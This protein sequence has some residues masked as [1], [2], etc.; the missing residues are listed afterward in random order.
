M[1]WLVEAKSEDVLD[2]GRSASC[3]AL[4]LLYNDHVVMRKSSQSNGNSARA[5]NWKRT[6]LRTS[7]TLEELSLRDGA[8]SSEVSLSAIDADCQNWPV[9]EPNLD[10]LE[11]GIARSI[12]VG[13]A[14]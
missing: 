13:W 9:S 1:S 2:M 5:I 6:F 8:G 3:D 4:S 12:P 7:D 11:V 10:R 14:Y